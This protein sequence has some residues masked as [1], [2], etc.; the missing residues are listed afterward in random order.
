MKMSW[1]RQRLVIETNTPV[2]FLSLPLFITS[3]SGQNPPS[4]PLFPQNRNE[5]MK[6]F[7]YL[8]IFHNLY[9]PF[10]PPPPSYT[11]PH[12]LGYHHQQRKDINI[13]CWSTQRSFFFPLYRV[14]YFTPILRKLLPLMATWSQTVLLHTPPPHFSAQTPLLIPFRKLLCSPVLYN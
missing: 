11:S 6:S 7:P 5:Q 2:D 10:T 8:H 3:P 9:F 14:W 12:V 13:F 1:V 4:P